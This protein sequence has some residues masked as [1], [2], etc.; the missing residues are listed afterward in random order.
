MVEY[1]QWADNRLVCVYTPEFND[2]IIESL[3]VGK[4][5][6][7]I[8]RNPE[9]GICRLFE[10]LKTTPN[11]KVLSIYGGSKKLVLSELLELEEL[12]VDGTPPF[13]D[14]SSMQSLKEISMDWRNNAFINIESSRVESLN[15]WKYSHESLSEIE[16]FC[17]LKQL[18]LFGG[19][20]LNI[21]SLRK[22]KV[23]NVFEIHYMRRLNSIEGIGLSTLSELSIENCKNISNYYEISQCE[24]LK[25]LRIHESSAISSL[26]FIKKLRFLE[27]IRFIK[28]DVSDSDL[29]YLI[30]INDVCFTQKKHFSHKLKDFK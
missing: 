4:V 30:G 15:L 7:L 12:L 28:T 25:I 10:Q 23:L 13:I 20:L 22:F 5:Q 11:L 8:I 18:R 19:R 14:F 16:G 24:N 26:V 3:R 1:E 27:S 9:E 21:K 6:G 17:Y 29:S 2:E